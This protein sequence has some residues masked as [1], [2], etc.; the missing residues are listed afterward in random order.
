MESL[1]QVFKALL[2]TIKALLLT[3]GG[4]LLIWGGACSFILLPQSGKAFVIMLLIAAGIA[5]LAYLIHN[6]FGSHPT[7]ENDTH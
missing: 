2:L 1:K 4:I 7:K 5:M 3:I 6:L